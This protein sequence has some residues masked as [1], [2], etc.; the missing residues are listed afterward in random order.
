MLKGIRGSLLTLFISIIL[1]VA[2]IFTRPPEA[3]PSPATGTAPATQQP[4]PTRPAATLPAVTAAP[5]TLAPTVPLDSAT[6]HEA[7]IGSGCFTKLNPLLAGYNRADRDAVALMFNGLMKTDPR[8]A[9]V[10]DL[11]SATPTISNDGLIYVFKLRTDVKW[12]DGLAFTSEDVLTT[13]A[14]L[15][16]DDFTGPKDLNQFWRTVEVD[17]LDAVTVRFKARCA[18]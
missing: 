8:G 18:P 2:V 4:T 9:I 7:L 13:I 14:A 11:A 3:I 16:A 5:I 10:P 1:L 17:V 12:H 6:L 15:Q